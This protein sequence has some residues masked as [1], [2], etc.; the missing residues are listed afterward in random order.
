MKKYIIGSLFI[1]GF[2]LIIYGFQGEI[3][4]N[5]FLGIHFLSMIIFFFGQSIVVGL[6]LRNPEKDPSSFPILVIGAIGF[7]MLTGLALLLIFYALEVENLKAIS[8]QFLAIYLIYLVFEMTVVLANLR[9]NS[10]D[11]ST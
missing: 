3:S 6:I 9:R 2:L 10:G 11:N 4:L 8:I 1:S 5:L 7:R